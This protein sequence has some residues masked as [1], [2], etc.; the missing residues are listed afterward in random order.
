MNDAE[1]FS[2]AVKF[3]APYIIKHNQYSV[4]T[5]D[6]VEKILGIDLTAQLKSEP[7]L[8]VG[9]TTNSVYYWNVATYYAKYKIL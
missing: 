3:I 5:W 4:I 8:G 6:K 7:I 9:P 2:Y 1:K